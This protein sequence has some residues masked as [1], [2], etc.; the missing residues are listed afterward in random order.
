M[1]SWKQSI[2]SNIPQSQQMELKHLGMMDQI[3]VIQDPL[4]FPCGS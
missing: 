3:N 1:V 2:A 4:E